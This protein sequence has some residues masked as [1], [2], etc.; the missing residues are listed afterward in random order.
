MS[1]DPEQQ[2]PTVRHLVCS[3]CGRAMLLVGQETH[4]EKVALDLL[5]FECD[6]G[7]TVTSTTGE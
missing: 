3:G 5:T 6:C 2:Q 7:H 4:P 1:W